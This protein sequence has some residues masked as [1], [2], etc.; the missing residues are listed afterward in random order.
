[1]DIGGGYTVADSL[2]VLSVGKSAG[3]CGLDTVAGV[4][5]TVPHL[6]HPLA[7]HFWDKGLPSRHLV[8]PSMQSTPP[9]RE[10]HPLQSAYAGTDINE[11]VRKTEMSRASLFISQPSMYEF[12]AVS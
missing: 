5:D 12:H 2:V 4:D 11:I 8:T 7:L 6:L 3:S 9:C 10:Q 1:M